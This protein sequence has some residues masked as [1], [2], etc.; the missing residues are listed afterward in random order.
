MFTGLVREIGRITSLTTR[1]QQTQLVVEAPQ[2]ASGLTIG[3]SLAVNGICLTVTALRGD[4]ISLD[5]VMETSRV[6]TLSTWRPGRRVHLE[7]AL[8]AGDAMGGHLVLGH[9]DEVG[10]IRSVRRV[11][12]NHLLE[13]NCS[14]AFGNWILPKG[15]VAV[16]GVSLTLAGTDSAGSF[17]LSLIP[18]TLKDTLLSGLRA[19]DTVNLEAD[20]LAKSRNSG[21]APSHLEPKQDL[22]VAKIR[23][24]G[25]RRRS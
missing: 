1:G 20:I 7:P 16:D 23:A 15:S 19:G 12:G 17:T 3:D 10:R 2:S 13:I 21:D 4:R 14:R 22:S 8:R 9:V 25:F 24:R 18:Q 5:A 6:T 11:G